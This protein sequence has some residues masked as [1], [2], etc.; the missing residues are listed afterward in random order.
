[1]LSLFISFS[2]SLFISLSRVREVDENTHT[3]AHTEAHSDTNK[4]QT[5]KGHTNKDLG[6][7]SLQARNIVWIL[8]SQ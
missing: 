7:G 3:Q 5:N 1:M 4:G 8:H 2:L 6:D